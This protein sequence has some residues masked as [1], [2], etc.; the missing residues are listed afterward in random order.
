MGETVANLT[1]SAVEVLNASTSNLSL[2]VIASTQEFLKSGELALYLLLTDASIANLICQR[3]GFGARKTFLTGSQAGIA[4]G[5]QLSA[6]V[7]PVESIQFTITGGRWAGTQAGTLPRGDDPSKQLL[8][9]QIEN[10]N[11]TL[12]PEIA[13]HFVQDGQTMFHNAAGLVLGGASSVSV[14]ATFCVFTYNQGA[15]SV[16]C[17]TEWSRATVF[18]ALAMAM[19]KDGQRTQAAAYF[20]GLYKGELAALG[21][22]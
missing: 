7:G 14:A 3:R 10:R 19:A 6:M 22:S 20:D 5:A 16:Q 9:L 17:P 2:G 18:G 1:V 4:N 12:N 11:V 8:E 21:A 15:S 13:P